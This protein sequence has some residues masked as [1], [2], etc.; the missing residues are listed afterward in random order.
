MA[1]DDAINIIQMALPEQRF[2]TPGLIQDMD[3]WIS[4]CLTVGISYPRPDLPFW[5][6]ALI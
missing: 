5:V 1:C 6:Q 2:L 3:S 4:R